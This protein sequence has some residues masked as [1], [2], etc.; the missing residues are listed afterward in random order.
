MRFLAFS[1]KN[2]LKKLFCRSVLLMASTN[3]K[4]P[5]VKL[6]LNWAMQKMQNTL[7][8]DKECMQACA[9]QAVSIKHSL[10]QISFDLYFIF[11]VNSGGQLIFKTQGGGEGEMEGLQVLGGGVNLKSYAITPSKML[12]GR[13]AL[14]LLVIYLKSYLSKFAI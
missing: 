3:K 5:I 12:T 14:Q 4:S 7:F 6:L 13:I 1:C 2:M 8:Q 9:H 11:L 10:L